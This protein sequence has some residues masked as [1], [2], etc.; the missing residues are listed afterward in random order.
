MAPR[1]RTAA[2]YHRVVEGDVRAALAYATELLAEE[3]ALGGAPP[4]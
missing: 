4:T 3:R 1:W 2:A